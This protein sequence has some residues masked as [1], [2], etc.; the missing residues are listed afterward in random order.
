MNNAMSNDLARLYPDHV[1]TLKNRFDRAL[2]AARFDAV[3]I[4]AGTPPM[5]FLDDQ[6]Y[7]FQ[8]NPHFNQWVP[9][10]DNPDCFVYYAPGERPRLLFHRPVDF[11]HKPADEP[12]A[13]WTDAFDLRLVASADAARGELPDDLSRCAFLGEPDGRFDGWGLAMANPGALVDRLHFDRAWKTDYELACLRGAAA[14]GCAAHRAAED[15]FR[16]GASEYEIH[17]AYMAA[18]AHEEHELPYNNIIALNQ[19][20]SVLH[21]QHRERRPPQTSLSFLIDAGARCLGYA[22]DITRTYSAADGTF[23]ELIAGMDEAQQALCDRVKPGMNYPD[24]QRDAHRHVGRLLADFGLVTCSAD[25]AVESGMTRHFFP[26]GVGHYIGLQVHDVGGFMA[27][28][29]GNTIAAPEDQ[30]FL[31]L[32]RTVEENQVFTV[33]PG[34]YFIE[35]LLADLKKSDRAGDVDWDRVDALRPYGGVRI[36]D[37][38]TVTLNG[39]ENM[40]RNAFGDGPY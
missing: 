16:A 5:K 25:A 9:V 31:R 2:E 13:F 33:E 27:D 24:L 34:L 18:C 37:N 4:H 35:P 32:T 39:H 26:H 11:W 29:E 8:V 28:P 20:G 1:A 40:T 3:L 15:A 10:T 7:P 19:H 23:A 38:V 12:D 22:S 14:L 21:Y 17:L 30:P 36:E 6:S